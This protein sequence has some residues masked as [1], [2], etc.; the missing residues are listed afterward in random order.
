[1]MH[2]DALRTHDEILLYLLTATC[3]GGVV[4][5]TRLEKRIFAPVHK[6][7]AVGGSVCVSG[8]PCIVCPW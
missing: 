6:V 2:D 5:E 7:E 3:S 4:I 1:M 8:L